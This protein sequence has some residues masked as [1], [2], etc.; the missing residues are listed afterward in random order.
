[1]K[2]ADRPEAAGHGD[3]NDLEAGGGEQALRVG[4]PL[5]FPNILAVN[6]KYGPMFQIRVPMNDHE[7]RH[8]WYQVK[9]LDPDAPTDEVPIWDNPYQ[10]AAGKLIVRFDD[11]ATGLATLELQTTTFDGGTPKRSIT[12]AD[13]IFLFFMV[14]SMQTPSPTSCN[15]SLSALTISTS[16]PAARRRETSACLRANPA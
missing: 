4:H 6:S 13:P 3:V 10:D 11:T 1:M 2:A 15:R 9:P 5:L 12:S 14:S 16:C 8:Y 7:T